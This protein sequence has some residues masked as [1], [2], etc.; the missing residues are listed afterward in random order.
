VL[1][2]NDDAMNIYSPPQAGMVITDNHGGCGPATSNIEAKRTVVNGGDVLPCS[3]EKNVTFLEKRR[4]G[5]PSFSSRDA[6]GLVVETLQAVNQ[7]RAITF[8][9]H[10]VSD[11]DRAIRSNPNDVT[12][13][14]CVM[15]FAESYS[16]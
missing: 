1:T 8:I 11:L 15:Q 4:I 6:N 2:T 3:L 12:V 10:I 5:S 9:K 16:V 7:H 13:E 14:R